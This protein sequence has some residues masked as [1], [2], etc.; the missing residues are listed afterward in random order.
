MDHLYLKW[1]WLQIPP[2][3][4]HSSPPPPCTHAHPLQSIPAEW[5]SGEQVEYWR[6]GL[7]L[8]LL[9]PLDDVNLRLFEFLR[10]YLW[11]SD[12]KTIQV[13]ICQNRNWLPVFITSASTGNLNFMSTMSFRHFLNTTTFLNTAWDTRSDASTLRWSGGSKMPKSS[14]N[15]FFRKLYRPLVFTLKIN[16]PRVWKI[17]TFWSSSNSTYWTI[18]LWQ[19]LPH[20]WTPIPKTQW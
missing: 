16:A 10:Q 11:I 19:L 1:F 3:C 17:K 18:S 8:G 2:G 20:H 15:F 13:D 12:L 5:S 14:F 9:P 4:H 7:E 6:A